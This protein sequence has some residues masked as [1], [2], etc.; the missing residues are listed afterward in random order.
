[1][2]LV[3]DDEALL[4]AIVPSRRAPRLFTTLQV[5]HSRWNS[6]SSFGSVFGRL[7]ACPH[8]ILFHTGFVLRGD[9]CREVAY[10]LAGA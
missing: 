8:A 4:L 6:V 7:V 3:Y 2:V 9:Q 5:V 1:M 10:P